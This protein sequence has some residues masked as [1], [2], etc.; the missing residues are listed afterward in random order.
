MAKGM[1]EIVLH[2]ALSSGS[3][4][5]PA[6]MAADL[7]RFQERAQEMAGGKV[8]A[9][10]LFVPG[11]YRPSRKYPLM[12]TLHGAGERGNDNASQLLHDFNA[13]WA[14][15]RFQDPHPFFVVAPQCPAD[16]QWVNVPWSLGSYDADKSDF[17]GPMKAVVAILDV[18]AGEFNIDAGRIYVSG[19]SMGGYAAWFLA[20]KYPHRFAAIVPVCGGADPRKAASLSDLPIWTFHAEDDGTVPVQ[21]TRE[22]VAALQAAGNGVIYTEYPMA[23]G[24]NHESWI[25]AGKTPELVPWIFRQ[26]RST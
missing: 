20:M 3:M 19:I 5:L 15:D 14:E 1:V 23:L 17:S 24:V 16:G 8:L 13:M 6:M 21:G 18:L 22:M 26:S 12:L 11:N 9:Y 10:R 7:S 2:R 25:P 4:G